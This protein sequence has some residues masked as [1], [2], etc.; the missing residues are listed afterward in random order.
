MRL[1]VVLDGDAARVEEDED[2]DEPVEPL[3][4]HGTADQVPA[5]R[6]VNHTLFPKFRSLHGV[7]MLMYV[8]TQTHTYIPYMYIIPGKRIHIH[9]VD[10]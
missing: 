3:L 7:L 2:D 6:N 8:H 5:Q 4:L 10:R 1:V 9:Y